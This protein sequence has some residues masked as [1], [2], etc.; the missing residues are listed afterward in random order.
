MGRSSPAARDAGVA[1]RPADC[2]PLH[3]LYEC[4]ERH[5]SRAIRIGHGT[6]ADTNGIVCRVARRRRDGRGSHG[7]RG[8]R[9]T[10]ALEGESAA[11]LPPRGGRGPSDRRVRH[12]GVARRLPS[13]RGLCTQLRCAHGSSHRRGAHGHANDVGHHRGDQ[14]RT[15]RTGRRTHRA[16]HRRRRTGRRISDVPASRFDGCKRRPLSGRLELAC[17]LDH[18]SAKAGAREQALRRLVPL[19]RRQHHLR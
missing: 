18:G 17:H 2:A 12:D 11:S 16:I 3:R 5:R 4:V 15:G 8:P 14:R 6:L 9:P 13:G 1:R 19:C 7:V 10:L